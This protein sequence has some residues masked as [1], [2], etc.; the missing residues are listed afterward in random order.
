MTTAAREGRITT[1]EVSRTTSGP[2]ATVAPN[3][4]SRGVDY[5]TAV[6]SMQTWTDDPRNGVYAGRS[7]RITDRYLSSTPDYLGQFIS[8]SSQPW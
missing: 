7:Y 4:S 3:G 1:T 2:I 8:S 6:V 5:W